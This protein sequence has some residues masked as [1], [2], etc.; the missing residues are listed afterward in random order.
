[1]KNL[2]LIGI[3]SVL[4]VGLGLIATWDEWKTKKD[5]DQEK[6]KN[7]VAK[8]SETQI[9]R[10]EYVSKPFDEANDQGESKQPTQGVQVV[11]FELSRSDNKWKVISPLNTE[12][13]QNVVSTTISSILEYAFTEVVGEGEANFDKFG[14]KD[15]TRAITF[16]VKDASGERPVQSWTIYIGNKVPVGYNVYFRTS[17]SNKI[18]MGSQ[19]LLLATAKTLFEVRD[20][21]VVNFKPDEIKK[22]YFS[23]T[24]ESPVEIQKKEST[25]QLVTPE[26]WELDPQDFTDYLNYL[27]GLKAIG[28]I[29]F[30][31]TEMESLIN[32]PDFEISWTPENGPQGGLKFGSKDN[33]FWVIR[34]KTAIEISEADFKKMN[35]KK[36]DFRSKKV[37]GLK[38]L[39]MVRVEID[40]A[41]FERKGGLWYRQ[42][43]IAK[44]DDQQKAK[45]EDKSSQLKDVEH[46]AAFMADLDFLKA[47]RFYAANEAEITGFLAKQPQHS[48][49]IEIKDQQAALKVNLYEF[50]SKE[51]FL[52][53]HSSS[54]LVYRVKRSDFKNM[55]EDTA[56][57]SSQEDI[58]KEG[59][60]GS[61]E[62]T[63]PEETESEEATD[64][65]M[66]DQEDKSKL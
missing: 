45:S 25:Y 1:M 62:I 8:F 12:A 61:D 55:K 24:G 60:L 53:K 28:F 17:D 66:K 6:T 23:K 21:T 43:D 46:I 14:L 58:L 65:T 39:D 52:L 29:D 22:F 51:F 18:Y 49:T 44:V 37:F 47:D 9:E 19:H 48:L 31:S 15:P 50:N 56:K 41:K 42:E 57:S 3:L 20:K 54:E 38:P 34:D 10:L 11:S 2:R 64:I 40:G 59:A 30:I 33:K 4:L 13:D 5:Q 35:R 27:G 16:H 36:E 32:H 63:L 26:N 7:R